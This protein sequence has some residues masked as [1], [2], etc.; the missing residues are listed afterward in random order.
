MR[1]HSSGMAGSR[2]CLEPSTLLVAGLTA[3]YMSRMFFMIFHGKERFSTE[4]SNAKHPHEAPAA[5]Y[6]PQILL[7]IGSLILGFLL[8]HFSFVDWL[9]PAIGHGEHGEPVLPVAV[10]T[11]LTL[12]LVAVGVGVA[13][14]M[15]LASTVPVVAPNGNFLTEAA[16]EDLYQDTVNERIFMDGGRAITTGVAVVDEYVVDGAV[17]GTAKATTGLGKIVA[18][19]QNGYVRTYASYTMVGAVVALLIALATRI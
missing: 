14:K 18:H 10:I 9:A 8:N 19:L 11:G 2:G 4:G 17:E 13:W 15:Y 5:M 1:R 3:F 7:A 16:R 12:A 6:V